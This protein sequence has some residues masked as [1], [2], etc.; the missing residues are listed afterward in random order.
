MDNFENLEWEESPP[1][2][3]YEAEMKKIRKNLRKRNA[4]I[5]LTSL[6]LVAALTFG[7]IRFGIPALEK[8]YWDPTTSTY[9]EGVPDFE[10]TMATYNE[11]FCHGQQLMS[12]DVTKTGFAEYSLEFGFLEWKTLNSFTDL[13]YRTATLNQGKLT[14]PTMFWYDF[15]NNYLVQNAETSSPLWGDYNKKSL[16]FLNQYPEYVQV[17]ADV[18]FS[19]DLTMEQLIDLSE[20]LPTQ[21]AEL[22][23]AAIRCGEKDETYLPD[24]G[25]HLYNPYVDRY[26]PDFW[27]NTDYPYLFPDKDD[28]PSTLMEEHF[29]SLLRFSGDQFASGTGIAAPNGDENFYQDA[30]NYVEENGVKSYGCHIIATPEVLRELMKEDIVMCINISDAWV[31]F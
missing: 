22:F 11:L 6:I 14:L 17:L 9:V 1:A 16:K 4:L 29:K 23:W 25:I 3:D 18:T 30:L 10:I 7:C 12:L 21:K 15:G 31:G 26:D 8:Q 24:C 27:S 13:S 28:D 5:V 2:F 20:R 19:E